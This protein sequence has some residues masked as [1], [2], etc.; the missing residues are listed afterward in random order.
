MIKKHLTL[1]LISLGLLLLLVATFPY[2]GGTADNPASAGYD[3][4]ENFITNLLNPLALNGME[5]AARPWAVGGVLCL[6]AA[7]GVFFS[8]FSTRISIKSAAFVIRYV[9]AAAAFCAFLTVI[10]PL[11]D[12]MVL[13]SGVMTLLVFFYITVLVLKSK[14]LFWKIYSI[15]ALLMLYFAT[16]M[17]FGGVLLAFLAIMQKAIHLLQF[18]WILGLEYFTGKEDFAHIKK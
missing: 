1:I 6:S 11:H 4:K 16:F 5:N 10:P 14:L 9:G 3:W 18:I 2:P 8:R 15:F 7:F 12:R 17:Y 13:F